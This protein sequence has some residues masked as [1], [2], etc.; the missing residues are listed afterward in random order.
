MRTLPICIIL[1][2]LATSLFCQYKVSGVILDSLNNEPMPGVNIIIS[3]TT[4][5]TISDLKGQFELDFDTI[6]VTI[7]IS[8]IGYEPQTRTI[9]KNDSLLIK[10]K[11][12]YPFEGMKNISHSFDLGY[13]GDV[14][15]APYG[16]FAD[17]CLDNIGKITNRTD[18]GLNLN[19]KYGTDGNS[20]SVS[21]F[22]I[23]Q[24]LNNIFLFGYSEN[25]IHGSYTKLN[26][27]HSNFS[28]TQIKGLLTNDWYHVGIDYGLSYFIKDTS[29]I[30]FYA[31]T[32]GLSLPS[33]IRIPKNGELGLYTSADYNPDY[34]FYNISIYNSFKLG[35][36]SRLSLYGTYYNMN[37]I[38]GFRILVRF[39]IF[40]HRNYVVVGY[41]RSDFFFPI[42][43]ILK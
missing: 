30:T 25:Y 12:G 3:G 37:D 28:L 20:N 41:P 40:L 33:L 18:I 21:Q 43:T 26:Y 2:F 39:R 14:I 23:N 19:F 4:K 9:Y 27:P 29:N 6:P 34:F 38:Q 1:S 7:S 8:F 42:H 24:K 5:G 17:Y 31:F 13:Y 32:G 35:E 10:M 16:I 15:Q 22:A 11:I 36:K